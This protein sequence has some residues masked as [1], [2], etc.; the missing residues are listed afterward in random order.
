MYNFR[1][2]F[3]TLAA[4][5]LLPAA[6]FA[7]NGVISGRVTAAEDGGPL[8]G[9]QLSVEGT[10]RRAVTNQQG[11]YE[12]T[13]VPAGAHVV[14]VSLLGRASGNRSVTVVAGQTVTADFALQQTALEL[15]GLV[16]NAVTGRSERKRE[17]G[18]N[19]A[20]ISVA[21]IPKGPIT[22]VADVLTGRTA[23]VN[24]QGV[25]GTTG[26][27]QKLRIRGANSLSLSNEP[28]IYVD[29]V[30]F[31]NSKGL[32][33]GVGGQDASRLNDLNAEDIEDIEILKGPAA[34]ALYGT[35][36]ANGV[37]LISTKRGRAGSTVYRAYAEGGVL[38]QT[39]DFPANFL[40]V[41][42]N[43]PNADLF[44]DAG[45]LNNGTTAAERAARTGP[46]SACT[47]VEAG[48]ISSTTGQPLCRQDRTVSFNPLE[49]DR[50]SPFDTGDR[51]KFGVSAS[52]GSE[53]VTFFLSA[54][55]EDETGVI[56]FNTLDKANLR[57][58]LNANLNDKLSVQLT[59]GYVNSDV[60]FNANDNNIFSPLINGLLGLP[61]F[62]DPALDAA[63]NPRGRPS[64]GFGFNISDIEE[65]ITFQEVDRFTVGVNTNYRPLSWLSGNVNL[66]LDYF[67]RTDS[68]TIQ[69]GR[70]PIAATFT[71]GQRFA[72][73]ADNYVYTGNTSGVAV[74]DLSSRLVSTS[75]AGASYNRELF[76]SVSCFGVG[77]VEGTRSCSAT[78]SQFSVGEGFSEVI[79]LGGFLQQQFALNDRLFVSGSIRGD[80]N[81]AFGT[82]LGFI[83]YPGASVSWVVSDE[84]FFPQINFLS[85]LR[86][87]TALGTSGLRPNFRDA[88][89]LFGPVSVATG[90]SDVSGVTLSATG[91]PD[92]EPERT[93][94]YELGLDAGL[95]GDRVSAEFT[96]FNK[97]SRDALIS[98]RLAPSFGLTPSVFDNLGEVRN[99]GTELGLN[100]RVIDA[101]K[102]RLNMRL[103]ATT[104]D[105]EI[106]ELGRGVEPIIFN[107]STQRHQE[108]FPT[109]A[110]FAR[111]FT[112]NDANNDGRLSIAEVSFDTTRFTV[113]QRT[114]LEGNLITDTIPEVF[115]GR[116]LPSNTQ[117]LAADLTLFKYITLSSLFERRAGMRQVNDTE[118]FRCAVGFGRRGST[119]QSGC[120]AVFDPDASLEDQAR[121]IADRFLGTPIGYIEDAEF[122]KWREASIALGIPPTISRHAPV[123]EGATLTLAGRNLATW[124]DYTGLDPE[125]NESGGSSN[126]TQG[127]FNTQ[128][129]V[130]YFTARLDLTF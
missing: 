64:F 23:G 33:V 128:P 102:F 118:S 69:P 2:L 82:D 28:L 32:S 70:L 75:T 37:V 53:A 55:K 99:S 44:T 56:D 106:E 16:A 101:D 89:T 49:D 6:G 25:S 83:Y 18:T 46:I 97:Q 94:E 10:V 62:L 21:E 34:S 30:L 14:D 73:N 17:L 41:Q 66:G 126:F 24:L 95:F 36:A 68:R 39:T 81:S 8:S 111:P 47:N 100:A 45:R 90:G 35:S 121:F 50:I 31:S 61:V 52:G 29:G 104:L 80:D 59:S 72:L 117:A 109:G 15:E 9:A 38:G 103:S 96:Y 92:L 122:V 112:F 86:V 40:T 3:A 84:P 129:P 19:T 13:G 91:N 22:K 76:E 87:R 42:V 130:R 20:S 108:G 120:S 43:D 113:V 125:I 124:T 27:S 110:F 74:F 114:D 58:N 11:R 26:T 51:T 63:A 119:G 54:D 4:L 116:A 60:A 65:I 12:I 48:T 67:S 88:V 77:V 1:M 98:R 78:A 127:E 105:N 93:T 7:Q 79:T 123:L 107:R 115:V 57:A 71:P 5:A 85:N